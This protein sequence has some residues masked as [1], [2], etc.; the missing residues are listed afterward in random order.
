M[1]P[2]NLRIVRNDGEEFRIDNE[3]W[4][5][6]NDGLEGWAELDYGVE[7]SEY[8]AYDGGIVTSRRVNVRDRSVT[9]VLADWRENATA[10]AEA[11][12]FF[13]PA[14]TY[15]AH[16]TYQGRTRWCEGVQYAFKC[17][18]GNV[19][20]PIQ[21]DWTVLSP[22][23]YLL[24]ED[25][26][27]KDIAEVVPK[28]G[29]PHMSA[30]DRVGSDSAPTHQRGFQTGLSVLANEATVDN[31][32]DVPAPCSFTIKAHGDASSITLKREGET[33]AYL[34]VNADVE[35]GDVLAID[36]STLPP[37]FELNGKDVS[38]LV[39][40]GS[41]IGDMSL[42]VGRNR[43][44]YSATSGESNLSVI[45]RFYKRYLGV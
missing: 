18:A 8:A 10:R 4:L 26:Y 22:M 11:I 30:I 37:T 2:V 19:Y 14:H 39:A 43:L 23:P 44:S 20:E 13:S 7:T 9:A 41:T 35:D 25:G 40:V 45:V 15:A 6:P 3:R 5:I 33:F 27:G 12:R 28:F 17:S 38:N 29:F 36:L 1:Q 32:G 34:T 21:I 31:D 24:S 16:L 42:E